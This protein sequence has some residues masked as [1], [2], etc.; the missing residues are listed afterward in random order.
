MRT[1]NVAGVPPHDMV[2]TIDSCS[3]LDT[4]G[5]SVSLL[6]HNVSFM[7]EDTVANIR[8]HLQTVCQ[9]AEIPD[10][11]NEM[12]ETVFLW[13]AAKTLAQRINKRKD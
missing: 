12:M 11:S 6:L 13:Q 1:K 7:P 8:G 3:V 9:L 5:E 10:I 4:M 2:V